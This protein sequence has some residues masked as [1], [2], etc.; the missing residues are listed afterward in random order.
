MKKVSVVTVNFNQPAVTEE[1]L[2][3]IKKTNTYASLEIIV[4][5][6]ASKINPVP[7]WLVTYPD[8]KS[9]RSDANLG[10][11]GGNNLGIKNATGDYIFLVNNDT[12]FTPGL[13][14]ALVDTLET[15]DEV[16]IV[17]PMI[18]YYSDSGV[19]QY[20]G[21]TPMDYYTCRN[22]CIG[23]REKDQGQF[24]HIIGPTAYCHGAAMM[25]K[26]EAIDKAGLMAENFFLYYEEVD[27]CEMIK[28]AGYEAWVNTDALIYHKE[29]ISVGKKSKLKEY[30]MNRNR[31]LFTR[32]NAP[33]HK[34]IFFF[35]YFLLLVVP[36]NVLAYIK[37]K[38]YAFIPML[39][40]AVW[41]NL[42][43]SKNSSNLGYPINTIA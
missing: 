11:A 21:Y 22:S 41:W 27:W 30:F 33:A 36:R 23:L 6:N 25:I 38:N 16:G 7:G 9:I 14:N 24:N 8:I 5:D 37:N 39:F 15:H 26:K 10:F 42:T 34:K 32:R 3:S 35:I 1:L 40:K 31:I 2:S 4:V 29:S 43:H 13:L 28:R 12:E 18:K 20:A 17:S 19:I